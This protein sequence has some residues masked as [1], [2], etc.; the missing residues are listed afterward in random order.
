ML[1][2]SLVIAD[3]GG[4]KTDWCYVKSGGER[5]Y[6]TT[7]SFHPSQWD[8]RFKEHF[9]N[10]WK[11]KEIPFDSS[12]YFFGAGCTS[13]ENKNTISD[14]FKYWGFSNVNIDSDLVGAGMAL[15]GRESGYFAILG[16]G[17]VCCMY[18]NNKV[19]KYFGGLGYIL[20][21]EGSGYYFGKQLIYSLLN[22]RLDKR[23]TNDIHN[24]IGG[25]ADILDRVYG[26]E[27][28]SFISS[29]SSL[30]K[31]LKYET[32]IIKLHETNF[33]EFMDKYVISNKIKDISFVG[34]YAFHH[35]DI[36]DKICRDRGV[37]VKRILQFPIIDL[38]DCLLRTSF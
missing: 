3:S 14:L 6:F 1:E 29:I 32:E 31:D 11:E 9:F 17:S 2:K 22:S 20:G 16:T 28:R 19:P 7:E 23:I 12:V 26:K 34:S 15:Y 13:I 18:E 24:L 33:N 10:F 21:D 5:E 8:G 36:F 35:Q 37:N 25:R 30:V 27:G 4:T 38:T